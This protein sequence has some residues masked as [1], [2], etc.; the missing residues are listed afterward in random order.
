MTDSSN[1]INS[2]NLSIPVISNNENKEF[3]IR[4]EQ[5]IICTSIMML[6]GLG[7]FSIFFYVLYSKI[8]WLISIIIFIILILI[9][10]YFRKEKIK[11]VKDESNNKLYI[12]H[13]NKYCCVCKKYS[14]CLENIHFDLFKIKLE[15]EDG[16]FTGYDFNLLIIDD[17]KNPEEIDLNKSTIN[18]IPAK[19]FYYYNNLLINK[20]DKIILK[21]N[22]NNWINSPT[23]YNNPLTPIM[24]EHLNINRKKNINIFI[25]LSEYFSIFYIKNPF[26]KN[27]N[28]GCM[29]FLYFFLPSLLFFSIASFGLYNKFDEDTGLIVC[30]ICISLFFIVSFVAFLIITI[31]NNAIIRID[32][33]YSKDFE[34]MFIGFVKMDEKSYRNTFK[35]KMSNIKEFILEN[36]DNDLKKTVLK[37][38]FNN[39]SIQDIYQLDD[40]SINE[41]KELIEH[42]NKRLNKDNTNSMQ[43]E[44]LYPNTTPYGNI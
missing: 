35:S 44:A 4:L 41:P 36:K 5:E 9:S 12:N 17:F 10:I 39:G 21:N 13:I 28:N 24:N 16:N 2:N 37:V 14:C 1:K 42:L 11:I 40:T 29:L 25:K 23:I 43:N 15:D 27:T 8:A 7:M 22:L 33:I 6:L 31:K 26:T 20:E 18:T 32:C 38:V 3:I 30:F 19:I 34:N